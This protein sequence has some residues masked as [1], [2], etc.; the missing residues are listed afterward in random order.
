MQSRSVAKEAY[1]EG[2]KGSDGEQHGVFPCEWDCVF[3]DMVAY[4]EAD[5]VYEAHV[6]DDEGEY[7]NPGAWTAIGDTG[8]G[9]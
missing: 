5:T 2:A 1:W 6:A 4:E 7:C 8:A 9:H 3:E